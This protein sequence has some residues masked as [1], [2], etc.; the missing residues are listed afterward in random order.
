MIH[1]GILSGLW[2]WLSGCPSTDLSPSHT[3]AGLRQ[4]YLTHK[5]S[6]SPLLPWLGLFL[7]GSLP[8]ALALTDTFLDRRMETW[9]N[10]FDLDKGT[11]GCLEPPPALCSVLWECNWWCY[12]TWCVGFWRSIC[13]YLC[14]SSSSLRKYCCGDR[15]GLMS[16]VSACRVCKPDSLSRMSRSSKIQL[17]FSAVP[18]LER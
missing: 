1:K 8:L 12:G 5:T 3:Q 15:N 18:D 7:S 11:T 6:S 4:K 2:C 14:D 13:C 9:G 10:K 16:Q 17:C